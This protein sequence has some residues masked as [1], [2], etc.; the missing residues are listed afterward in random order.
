[1]EEEVTTE[2]VLEMSKSISKEELKSEI[3][4]DYRLACESREASLIGRR[5]VLT[6]KAKFGI[7][8]DGKEVAQIALAKQFKKGDWRS[9][10]Y[11]D[12]TF[13]M[14][15]EQLTLDEFFA[16]LYAHADVA[17]DPNSGG[18]QMNSHFATRLL[19]KKGQWKS[20]LEQPN[21]SAD[22]SP[23]ASQMPRL[24]GLAYASHF[25]RNNKEL[26]E[27]HS[28]F[29]NNGD[30]VAFGMIGDA[31]T[32]E[33]IFW[34]TVN[35]AGVL[36][37]PMV[38]A[39]WDDGYGISV[40]KKYQTTKESISKAL[41]G[42]QRNKE[43]SGIEI[44]RT[45]GWD[46]A[47][48]CLT[49]EKAVALA[50]TNH[51]PVLVHVEEIT[52]PQGHSTS[53]SHERY[54]SAERLK[55][56]TDFD[57]LA[58][59]KQWIVSKGLASN[60]EIDSI[61]KEAKSNVRQVKKKSWDAFQK[62]IV[63][64]KNEVITIVN[65][66]ANS[67][68]FNFIRPIVENLHKTKEPLRNDVLKTA[69]KILFKLSK[70]ANADL[71]PLQNWIK[72]Y[73]KINEDKFNTF[74]Y[75]EGELSPLSTEIVPAV[76]DENA[77]L[78]DGREILQSNF[79]VLLEK[80]KEL[81]IFGEDSGKIGGVNQGLAGLQEK[82]GNLRVFDTGIR[83]ATIM[84]QGIGLALRG[85]RPIAEIQY[86]DYFM[87]AIQI[88]S[89]DLA[90]LHYRTVGGQKAPLIIR[91]R[92]HRLEGIWHAGSQLGT[93]IHACRGIYVCVPRNMTQ[94]AGMY[95]TLLAGDNPA[96]VIESLNGYRLK[97]KEP[98]N[99]GSFKVPLG[100]PEVLVEGDDI[101]LVT[102]GSMVRMAVKVAKELLAI[103]ISCEVID[104]QTLLP[105]DLNGIVSESVE[106]T[107]KV[108][109]VDEDVPGGASAFMLQEFLEKQNG[110]ELL[111]AAP[112]T[113]AAKEHR[114]AYGSDG[115]Y[116]S[117]PSEEDIFEAVYE[118]MHEYDP[119]SFPKL[120]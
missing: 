82:Y 40:E 31:S 72:E 15:A 57:C 1:M 108:I 120:Y 64:A 24:L 50:R 81:L 7:F 98:A 3:L 94:A 105:F 99:I 113:L 115:D 88:I 66:F 54:K 33:G 79:D 77:E 71:S 49:F 78:K 87:Y 84:G 53:G 30:E 62:D 25:Y 114:P 63:Q 109:F 107:N 35:A 112:R 60:E 104:V 80:Y 91:T 83:E 89:D 110:F 55:W 97:E 73:Q 32:S 14:A 86:L 19:D 100:V 69:R 70:D 45:L 42:M 90:S 48:L 46:Y 59:M 93:I 21:T 101:T 18:R 47:D 10:Y 11:R 9:G 28:L 85:L 27:E 106:K 43:E 36:Q 67:S 4:S 41:S 56:E 37:V 52:Q 75:S 39:I 96:I 8:G 74:L 116:F 20:H 118:I 26:Q 61:E 29:S 22:M 16:Q 2:Q 95:N 6:G 111:D 102:Y 13:M 58:Q 119:D 68:Q 103:G 34:E 38:I 92:G 65:G 51:I 117:K 12:Q 5:E 76:Y 44:M 23:T 17:F